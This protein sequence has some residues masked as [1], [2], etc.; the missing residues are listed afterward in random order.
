MV[1]EYTSWHPDFKWLT[2]N[3]VGDAH[4]NI[5]L[6]HPTPAKRNPLHRARPARG[7]AQG[8]QW[9]CMAPGYTDTHMKAR[10]PAFQSFLTS[11]SF[12]V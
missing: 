7:L 3:T 6:P 5:Y 2:K 8:H 12:S 1:S 11:F 4:K 10:D 9:G